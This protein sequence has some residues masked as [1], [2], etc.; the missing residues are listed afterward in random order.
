MTRRFHQLDGFLRIADQHC[1]QG[2]D[3]VPQRSGR[4][5]FRQQRHQERALFQSVG[6]V[7]LLSQQR[8]IDFGLVRLLY[9]F[10]YPADQHIRFALPFSG[11]LCHAFQVFGTSRFAVQSQTVPNRGCQLEHPGD[12]L[13]WPGRSPMRCGSNPLVRP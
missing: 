12:P 5:D 2:E 8:Q 3:G 1:G 9:K 7:V 11:S 6:R 4:F 10:A 13:R